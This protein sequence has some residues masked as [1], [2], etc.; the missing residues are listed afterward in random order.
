MTG[1][2]SAA[3]VVSSSLRPPTPTRVCEMWRCS[4]VYSPSVNDF[5]LSVGN[6]YSANR[7]EH[8]EKHV[9]VSNIPPS[10][11]IVSQLLG[12]GRSRTSNPTAPPPSPPAASSSPAVGTTSL[13]QQLSRDLQSFF[14]QFQGGASASASATS[15]A[16][17]TA[18]TSA[19]STGMLD[20]GGNEDASSGPSRSLMQPPRHPS[21]TQD[22]GSA[23]QAT[24]DPAALL[25]PSPALSD[26]S[27]ATTGPARSPSPAANFLAAVQA[28]ATAAGQ[29]AAARLPG[30]M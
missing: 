10:G 1:S 21:G 19:N 26:S 25:S 17:S 29:S 16:T 7:V 18:T 24:G 13:F 4:M 30:D 3:D 22:T 11:S 15:G 27:I 6:C 28:Y 9:S 5:R 12:V 8:G 20:S 14:V 23:D 2:G